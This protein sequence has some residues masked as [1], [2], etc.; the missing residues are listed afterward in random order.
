[1]EQ[2]GLIDLVDLF[3][4]FGSTIKE[5]LYSPIL[6]FYNI[7]RKIEK[8]LKFSSL[9]FIYK[10]S[11]T[12]DQELNINEFFTYVSEPLHLDDLT[13]KNVF[14][15]LDYGQKGKISVSDFALVIDSYR[16]DY[17]ENIL[18]AERLEDKKDPENAAIQNN[19]SNNI[20]A[21][22]SQNP[23]YE[24]ITSNKY[25]LSDAQLYW[26]NKF[27]QVAESVGLTP[28]MVFNISANE[29]NLREL[30][31]DNLKK[32]LKVVFP[33]SKI[34]A[35]E[36]THICDSLDINK[37]GIITFDEYSE[38]IEICKLDPIFSANINP[39]FTSANALGSLNTSGY[40]NNYNY[41]NTSN[42]KDEL[43]MKKL[44][45]K[46]KN[47]HN[48]P[49][50]GN[51]RA[52]N[53]IRNQLYNKNNY[54]N[55]I[56]T[57]N[58]NN[59]NMQNNK[60]KKPSFG[61]ENKDSSL[62]ISINSNN[63]INTNDYKN[64]IINSI[65][66]NK[67]NSKN[68]YL[69]TEGEENN[70]N[71]QNKNSL[72]TQNFIKN[73]LRELDVFEN[74]EWF[75]ID[76]LE[77]IHISGLALPSFSLYNLLNVKLCPSIARKTV[78][79]ISKI[80]DEDLDGYVTYP[81]LMKFL[82]ENLNHTSVKLAL[83]D[84]S[85]LLEVESKG[86]STEEF[87][88]R[89]YIK[90]SDEL[91]SLNFM[92]AVIK[93]FNLPNLI[94]KKLYYELKQLSKKDSIS[95]EILIDMINEYR[96]K[97]SLLENKAAAGS[98]GN[99]KGKVFS[100]NAFVDKTMFDAEMKKLVK[101]LQRCF[102][103]LKI[104]YYNNNRIQSSLFKENLIKFLD[105][106]LNFTLLQYRESFI[107][108]LD[109]NLSLGITLFN[110]IKNL[111]QTPTSAFMP[112]KSN[113]Y[114]SNQTNGINGNSGLV[115]RDDLINFITSYY[116]PLINNFELESIIGL[117]EKNFSPLKTCFE[118]IEYNPNGL[119]IFELIKIFEKYYP[120]VAKQILI[121]M[122]RSIDAEKKGVIQYKNINIF[123]IKYSKNFKFSTDLFF[124][125]L[126]SIIDKTNLT[127]FEYFLKE[128][129]FANISQIN[130]KINYYEHNSFFFEKLKFNFEL[131]DHIFV[132]LSD[133]NNPNAN[134]NSI[135]INN[136]SK[137]YD[138]KVNIPASKTGINNNNF[139]SE[140]GYSFYKLG[141][142]I[143]FYRQKIPANKKLMEKPVNKIFDNTSQIEKYIQESGKL[144]DF[145]DSL[146]EVK[147]VENV[148]SEISI[149]DNF[150]ISIFE[151]FKLINYHYSAK[152]ASQTTLKYLKI[153]DAEKKGFVVYEKFFKVVKE[154]SQDD[155]S[156]LID[157]H[158]KYIAT[159]VNKLHKG[160]FESFL[161]FKNLTIKSFLTYQE[162]KIKFSQE[163]FKEE[164]LTF[165]IF[166]KLKER[167][168]KY[169]N[170]L[171][172]Q[173]F[174]DY[175]AYQ[176]KANKDNLYLPEDASN[177]NA[178]RIDNNNASTGDKGSEDLDL[179]IFNLIK[180]SEDFIEIFLEHIDFREASN[181]GKIC[182][183][184][185]TKNLKENFPNNFISPDIKLFLNR[186]STVDKKFDLIKFTE[187]YETKFH[188]FSFEEIT[189]KAQENI[190]CNVTV[191]LF[192]QRVNL[193]P[194]AYLTL[195]DFSVYFSALFKLSKYEAL[196]TFV[197]LLN[198][199]NNPCSNEYKVS[200]D[201]FL[202]EF[203][204]ANSFKSDS[205][206]IPEA[207]A[208][209]QGKKKRLDKF[210]VL[211]L[212]KFANFLE[213]FK[214]KIDLF[215]SFDADS[216]GVLTR[217]EFKKLL[218][219][220]ANSG[221]SLNQMQIASILNLADSNGDELI[222]YI[223]FIEFINE[224]KTNYNTK[225]QGPGNS[226]FYDE[227]LDLNL[228]IK[229]FSD[230]NSVKNITTK[231]DM[232]KLKENYEFNLKN[233]FANIKKGFSSA[234]N[235]NSSSN[236]I[237]NNKD[238]GNNDKAAIE[239]NLSEEEKAFYLLLFNL[240]EDFVE[241]LNKFIFDVSLLEIPEYDIVKVADVIKL[242]EQKDKIKEFIN[243]D[244]K[245]KL[246]NFSLEGFNTHI[247]NKL[248]LDKSANIKNF[249]SNVIK[250]R[251][252][253]VIKQSKEA[254]RHGSPKRNKESGFELSEILQGV[255]AQNQ[256]IKNVIMNSFSTKRKPLRKKINPNS[257]YINN[258]NDN[259]DYDYQN[260]YVNN[261]A[262]GKLN[263]NVLNNKIKN[264]KINKNNNPNS[265]NYDEKFSEVVYNKNDENK[266]NDVN[267]NT[268]KANAK[269]GFI[270]N[271]S[272]KNQA[273]KQN[274]TQIKDS[275]AQGEDDDDKRKPDPP[276]AFI[277]K[278]KTVVNKISSNE[279][280][281][282]INPQTDY[283]KRPDGKVVETI[284][285]SEEA[286]IK[287]CEIIFNSLK[288]KEKFIDKDF[289]S[290][291][292]DKGYM[293]KI[294]LYFNGVA[295]RGAFDSSQIE[296]YRMEE[297]SPDQDPLFIS[298]GAD[299]N[300]VI[301]GSLGDCWFIS[302]LSVLAT[303]D[304]LLR[305]EFNEE[306]L[307]DGI[308]DEEE[309]LMLST[310]VYPPI[311]HCFRIKNIFCFKFFKDFK[312]RYVIIDDRLPCRKVTRNQIP[313]LIYARCKNENEFWVPLIEKAYAKLHGN[314]ESLVS[315]FVDEGLVDLTGL[316]ARKININL[317]AVKTADKCDQLWDKL[318]EYSC[319]EYEKNVIKTDRFG[320]EIKSNILKINNTMMG[321]S[322]D[323][324]TVEMDVVYN[325]Q[326]CGL[327]ARH[328]YSIL[329]TIEIP[330][331]NSYK[332]R[333]KSRL[334]RIRNPWG[335]KE[336]Q[337]KWSDT[338]SELEQNK[339]A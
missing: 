116:D 232:A 277:N 30:Y 219:K 280:D 328:A 80:I 122:L 283:F 58:K 6:A 61:E 295:P 96:E 276:H 236:A 179:H 296:W 63:D 191:K 84:M 101:Y 225:N 262:S 316:S 147:S 142:N 325:N 177:S 60:S 165:A 162:F 160:N 113:N 337:G 175:L 182:F 297:I 287:K 32:K 144:K 129:N 69:D 52:L 140:E 10:N 244:N 210:V 98:I 269:G 265:N 103:C 137:N 254:S 261:N 77:D 181:L 85:R 76:I 171:N 212:F 164:N 67:F 263:A 74:G 25:N 83:K 94:V 66:K 231:F 11:L 220:C 107:S 200:F 253:T 150:A 286:A 104:D 155:I 301:Q 331:L 327:L 92:Q 250:F 242:L 190:P 338:S 174:I 294:S 17:I 14:K 237:N 172:I 109:V 298:D 326:K 108:A 224:I 238:S 320:K 333:K 139:Y 23:A 111:L 317:D 133:E 184:N 19:N 198:S 86:I 141:K 28:Y 284:L 100:A 3:N 273:G 185:V 330:K 260:S 118:I 323:A 95:A 146:R 136:Y 228:D 21:F 151:L 226:A 55:T 202:H 268:I 126:A 285:N 70:N 2:T 195:Q 308:I 334:L 209:L 309:N 290:Q 271:I 48:L 199:E 183:E 300:D 324:K 9:E 188:K 24:N 176:I 282:V 145:F 206:D 154:N 227:K 299:S 65:G 90:A 59:N 246:W 22:A 16:D 110:E 216:D 78:F 274:Q 203:K 4:S 247:K 187:W 304:H 47:I 243:E 93:L 194:Y 170:S 241:N 88:K 99:N 279:Y 248:Y 130:D 115:S 305:G 222:N 62:S 35:S 46:N 211:T 302:A 258:N 5:N 267:N 329:D 20:A 91:N 12:L 240:Q 40:N 123:L 259:I 1:M 15:C 205:A 201:L 223:E 119:V 255:E 152:L 313:K 169:A 207:Q 128:A 178:D 319:V 82:L 217:E 33:S 73:F 68:K 97:Y 106:P 53:S 45:M 288:N 56:N 75:L 278:F 307:E 168:G 81:N 221:V 102:A 272:N 43:Q 173:V 310:G 89:N 256:Q 143:D 149:S 218:E 166:E 245:E 312:W 303:K 235:L 121:E 230:L 197:M 34:S 251:I 50:R 193:K 215:K 161:N 335:T 112:S 42:K 105:L 38:I 214:S 127:T 49:V 311:F 213:N 257:N 264:T 44:R 87:F 51:T 281:Y 29:K 64:N 132:Y 289:G 180:T 167:K 124:K 131:S 266:F 57:G 252:N 71:K 322:I 275:Y 79:Q 138:N 270:N 321:V 186:F 157:L 196:Y 134:S 239:A 114:V 7:S 135:A 54:A 204:L 72:I 314:Y 291:P 339:E 26:I 158:M 39:N 332:P 148:F 125:E 31:L 159:S 234:V 120:R 27:L 41:N 37:K 36:I 293:N 163:F 315:G 156:C 233:Y 18:N 208:N 318:K 292:D 189:R 229:D 13:S 336:W 249:I 8:N 192:F 117:I 306:I 153:L